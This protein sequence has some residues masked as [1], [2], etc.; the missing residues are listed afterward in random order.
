LRFSLFPY[1]TLFRSGGDHH[2]S[3]VVGL[4]AADRVRYPCP[5]VTGS[6]ARR[7]RRGERAKRAG[8]VAADERDARAIRRAD[9]A[10]RPSVVQRADRKSTRLNSSH[11]K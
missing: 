11:V 7:I 10:R 2:V 3:L 4:Q 8:I 9:N 5:V 6:G 1:T